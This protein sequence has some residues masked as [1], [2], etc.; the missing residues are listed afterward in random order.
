MTEVREILIRKLEGQPFNDGE[1]DTALE[2]VEQCIKNYC[3]R[4][5]VP[6]ALRFTWANM[7]ADL[8]RATG[9]GSATIPAG[10]IAS[11]SVGDVT[12]TRKRSGDAELGELVS[13]YRSQLNAFRRMRW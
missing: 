2:E 11:I 13:S 8:L 9:G 5:S 12:V 4:S 3:N 6:D 1:L 7:A 10:E